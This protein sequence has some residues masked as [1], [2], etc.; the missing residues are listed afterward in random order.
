[1]FL[2]IFLAFAGH[3]FIPRQPER[4][5]DRQTDWQTN[6]RHAVPVSLSHS[7]PLAA[8]L[9]T[10]NDKRRRMLLLLLLCCLIVLL[11]CRC[12][13]V[14]VCFGGVF[15]C[16]VKCLDSLSCAF[17]FTHFCVLYF[18]F[19]SY[20]SLFLFLFSSCCY[21]KEPAACRM[22]RLCTNSHNYIHIFAIISLYTLRTITII[23][24]TSRQSCLFA[25]SCCCFFIFLLLFFFLLFQ[26]HLLCF[27]NLY[28]IYVYIYN[29][30]IWFWILFFRYFKFV[31]ARKFQQ[32]RLLFYIIINNNNIVVFLIMLLYYCIYF[33]F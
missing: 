3:A 24:C 26:L 14:W 25:L 13:C 30:L 8:P 16:T 12:L 17:L 31:A 19:T 9:I 5:T 10:L 15:A 21:F 11:V 18:V 2:S 33:L 29:N 22:R 1:M 20:F 6:C 27:N 23:G 32:N 28:S 4:H 7:L